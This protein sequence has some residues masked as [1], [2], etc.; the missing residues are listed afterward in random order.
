[1]T[2]FEPK[3]ADL[4]CKILLNKSK[5]SIYGLI[6]FKK[7]V[8]MPKK[9]NINFITIPNNRKKNWLKSVEE[10][11]TL[12]IELNLDNIKKKIY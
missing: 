12:E 11:N 9:T 3:L 8:L 4:I 5:N 6:I 7:I 2:N 10:Q 1:M